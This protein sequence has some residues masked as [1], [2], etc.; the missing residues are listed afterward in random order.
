M[1]TKILSLILAV[2]VTAGSAWKQITLDWGHLTMTVPSNA[3][4]TKEPVNWETDSY[5]VQQGTDGA[6]LLK[7]IVGGGAMDLKRFT[8]FCL[9]HKRAWRSAQSH[10]I[11]I[12][13]GNPGVD[14]VYLTSTDASQRDK[15]VLD[16][17]ILSVKFVDGT[18]C[19]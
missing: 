15:K 16:K 6:D 12:V 17:M 1:T 10:P 2:S 4:V 3:K 18:Y 8:P 19:R 14:A 11:T 7:I 9:N 13:V 5:T